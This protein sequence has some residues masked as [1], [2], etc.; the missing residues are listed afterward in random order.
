MS[1]SNTDGSYVGF[2]KWDNE[3]MATASKKEQFFC[4]WREFLIT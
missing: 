2:Q 4:I 3:Q 1:S